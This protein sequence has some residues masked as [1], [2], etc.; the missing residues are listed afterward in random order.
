MVRNFL[1]LPYLILLI[2]IH[3]GCASDPQS[4]HIRPGMIITQSCQI[5]DSLAYVPLQDNSMAAITI[6]GNNLMIDF[7]HCKLA[8]ATDPLRP[9]L[10]LGI[11]IKVEGKNITLKNARISGYK[12][13]LLA[14]GVDSLR[15]INSDFSYNYRQKLESDRERENV[16]DWLYYHH[17]EQDEWKRYGAGIYL[18]KCSDILIREVKITQGQNGIMLANCNRAMIFNNDIRF[19]SGVGIGLYRSSHNSIMH[20]RL[21]FNVRGYSHG[22]YQRGQDSAG[23]LV[24]EQSSNNTFAYNSATHSGDGFFLWAGQHTMDTGDGGCSNNLIFSNDFSYAPTNGIEVTFSSNII[25]GNFL[26]ECKYGIWGGYSHNTSILRNKISDCDFGIAIEN[27]NNNHIAYNSIHSCDIGIKLWDRAQQPSDWGFAK[28][29]NVTGRNYLISHNTFSENRE[30]FDV[31]LQENTL[32]HGNSGEKIPYQ[33]TAEDTSNIQIPRANWQVPET[34]PDGI[35]VLK[36]SMH[37]AGRKNI[38]ITEWGPYNFAYPLIWLRDLVGDKYIFAIL[39]PEGNWKVTSAS[40]LKEGSITAG[41]FPTTLTAVRD[42]NDSEEVNITL[43]YIGS[44]FTDQF[45]QV[46]NRGQSYFFKYSE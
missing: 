13:G 39:G 17:N 18:K 6:R 44:Q 11:G 16:N 30:P 26:R 22:V 35:D 41:T 12:I 37:L 1:R 2:Q 23:L 36:D 24:Y 25:V 7:A 3:P 5:L 29:R 31:V 45:G 15:L 46:N 14:E 9:D 32:L 21:D 8:G 4:I 28:Y 42:Y 40:G 33:E 10:F 43:E 34:I 20:N 38:I 27:G 19:N